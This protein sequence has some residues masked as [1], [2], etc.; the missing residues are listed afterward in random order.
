MHSYDTE[1]QYF[2]F[3]STDTMTCFLKSEK[4]EMRPVVFWAMDEEKMLPDFVFQCASH[5]C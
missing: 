5:S 3:Q 1:E 4:C 2:C